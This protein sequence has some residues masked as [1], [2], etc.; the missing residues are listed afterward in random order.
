MQKINSMSLDL[1]SKI[2]IGQGLGSQELWSF[3]LEQKCKEKNIPVWNNAL[4]NAETPNAETAAEWSRILQEEL[5]PE[6]TA[7]LHS[8]SVIACIKAL[9]KRIIKNLVIIGGWFTDPGQS[10]DP[11]GKMVNRM[12]KRNDIYYLDPFLKLIKEHRPNWNAIRDAVQNKVLIVQSTDDP[13]I[14]LDQT[15][16]FL[17]HFPEAELLMVKNAGHFQ[18]RPARGN[19]P[20]QNEELPQEVQEKIFE[21]VNN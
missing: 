5:T 13:Y 6:T 3:D 20:A 14:H 4:P 16:F 12:F 1:P 21:I 9:R 7:V 19:K 2:V 11:W 8:A 15:E 18:F 10:P 17:D